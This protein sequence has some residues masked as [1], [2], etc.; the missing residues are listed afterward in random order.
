M[1]IL[2]LDDSGTPSLNKRS[3]FTDYISPS[4]NV[5]LLIISSVGS[6]SEQDKANALAY[7]E[8]HQP[9]SNGT[10]ELIA[11]E[12]HKTHTVHQIYTR[13]EDLILRA[14]YLRSLLGISAGLQESDAIYFRDKFEMKKKAL[15][16]GF[17]VPAFKRVWSPTHILS[18]IQDNG[19]PVGRFISFLTLTTPKKTYTPHQYFFKEISLSLVCDI[20]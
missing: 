7:K 1:N 2:I 16:G 5:K 18:F 3:S 13:Q 17:P 14:A 6:L 12:F 20:I 4:E 10:L 9:T 15:E 19:Y 8:I 11:L